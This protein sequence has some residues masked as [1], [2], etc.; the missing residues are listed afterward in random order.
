MRD[1][2]VI[3]QLLHRPMIQSKHYIYID[4]MEIT[5]K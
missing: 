4:N 1:G 2:N 5:N 3:Y